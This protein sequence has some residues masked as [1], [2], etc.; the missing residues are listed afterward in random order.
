MGLQILLVDDNEDFLDSTKDVLEIEGYQVV[1]ATSGKQALHLAEAGKFD[2]ILMDIKMPKMNG[3]E[4]FIKMKEYDPNVKVIL[5]TAYS[6]K[7]LVKR[8][9][10]EGAHAIFS[11]PLEMTRL[12][13][14][15]EEARFDGKARYVLLLDDDEAFCDS[16]RDTLNRTGYEVVF[17]SNCED[18]VKKAQQKS[19][20]ILLLDMK[21]PTLN[22][23]E[24]FRR[25]KSIQPKIVTIIISGYVEEMWD[26]IQEALM[27]SVYTCLSKPLDMGRLLKV[28][29]EVSHGVNNDI[30]DKKDYN[31]VR[32]P[33]T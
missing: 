11:K 23:L 9:H 33:A 28:L 13:R 32:P 21:L 1:T 14:A 18:A 27:E 8:A 12:I 4:A 2:I 29:K 17:A 7:N 15:I 30:L 24:A 25:K 31:V 22:G 19:Y 3:V 20:D 6:L 26:I 5:F 10:Q 16:L